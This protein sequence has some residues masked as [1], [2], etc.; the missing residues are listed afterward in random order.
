MAIYQSIIGSSDW[1][2]TTAIKYEY[3]HHMLLNHVVIL[4]F[5]KLKISTRIIKKTTKFDFDS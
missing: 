1:D 2:F 4:D 3:R 5:L